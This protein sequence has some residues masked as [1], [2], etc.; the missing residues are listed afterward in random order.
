MVSLN[1]VETCDATSLSRSRL[2]TAT[3]TL[4]DLYM[5][6]F[7]RDFQ[8]SKFDPL[9]HLCRNHACALS[10]KTSTSQE[11]F[12]S[13]SFEPIISVITDRHR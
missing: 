8:E 1:L 3:P 4:L 5:N 13:V 6:V 7:G 9:T 11:H 12:C 10:L 2:S